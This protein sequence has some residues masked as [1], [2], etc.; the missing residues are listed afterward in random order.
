MMMMKMMKYDQQ[1]YKDHWLK[2]VVALFSEQKWHLD[3]HMIP[4]AAYIY[5]RQ[6]KSI[7][8]NSALGINALALLCEWLSECLWS[9]ISKPFHIFNPKKLRPLALRATTPD[10]WALLFALGF[11]HPVLKGAKDWKFASNIY[12][13]RFTTKQSNTC[14]YMY[15]LTF[16][17]HVS[18]FT[19]KS[20]TLDFGP[21]IRFLSCLSWHILTFKLLW[22]VSFTSKTGDQGVKTL[23][24]L[25][26]GTRRCSQ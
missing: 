15:I 12:W 20:G 3:F 13:E 11:A 7:Q 2:L 6:F 21:F 17:A 5:L 9:S 23:V 22:Q 8:Y 18:L 14:I 4:N 26:L 24:H 19:E 16:H 10:V 1:W 25:Q